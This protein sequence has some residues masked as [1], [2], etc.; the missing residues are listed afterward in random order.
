MV[1]QASA[2]CRCLRRTFVSEAIGLDRDIFQSPP[3]TPRPFAVLTRLV[4]ASGSD[5]S[6]GSE[7]V[8]ERCHRASVRSE[9]ANR[10][11][12]SFGCVS[13]GRAGHWN[14]PQRQTAVSFNGSDTYVLAGQGA[15]TPG[16]C[17]L[18]HERYSPM[19]RPSRSA[20]VGRWSRRPGISRSRICPRSNG[21][22]LVC[23]SN[24][25]S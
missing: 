5:S 20:S 2:E 15:P 12:G 9:T 22:W 13:E 7:L 1:V 6:S 19:V 21:R 18:S 4:S 23:A 11:A 25:D 24:S 14:E 17:L 8:V 3:A 10:I 16:C